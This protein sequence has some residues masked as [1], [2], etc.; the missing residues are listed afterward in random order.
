ML[1]EDAHGAPPS[2]P[3]WR[4]EA[5]DRTIELSFHVSELRKKISD[6]LS[7][8]SS[9]MTWLT[10][11][12]GLDQAGAEQ[13]LEYIQQ[14]KAV[15][16]AVPTQ[17]AVIAE[18]FFDESGGMQLIIHAPFG[19]RINKAWG[20]ALRKK[21]CRSFNFEL[22]AAATEDGLNIALAEQHSF[23]LSDVFHYLH[24]NTIK[25]VLVQAVLQSPLFTTRWRWDATRA[26][27]LIRFRNGKKVPPNIQ[28]MLSDDL[29]AAIFPD[30]AAC[31]DNLGGREIELPDHPLIN[32]TMKDCL[33]EALD[34]DGL[35]TVLN[36]ILNGSIQC[37]AVDT[38][39]PSPFSHEI[40]NA[41]P[42]AFLDD[43]PLEERRARAVEMRRILPEALLKEV[44]K[45]DPDAIQEVQEQAWP[46]IRNRDELHDF[47]QTVIALPETKTQQWQ[48]LLMELE[49]EGRIG[50]AIYQDNS[51]Y[52]PVEKLKSFIV[53]Y[54]DAII[55]NQ[56]ID[57]E[58]KSP[59]RESAM[60]NMIKGWLMHLIPTTSQELKE[61][62]QLDLTEIDQI[63]LRLESTGLILQGHYTTIHHT[64]WCE[65][66]LLA[67]IHKLT[68]ER[69]R[70]KIEPVSTA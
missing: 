52:F 70:K 61:L 37:L 41:N 46:D 36:G 55:K 5:P 54:P 24:P 43:A 40:L 25:D 45:L 18:R 68:V 65:R 22:Q 13:L 15:L 19:S 47:L 67:R 6:M 56:L 48:L 49:K 3:F 50:K 8:I 11:Y 12:C 28:R 23:P 14:G 60:L 2:V 63:L 59:D 16:G 1:V 64:E 35:I 62:L 31:Q 29:L 53:I 66:R 10:Q 69:L 42:Y 32:E 44:G 34:I 17:Q 21:F 51:F 38:P 7:D 58:K 4:G 33:T 9:A 27:A 30:A 26:L 20:L 39:I 57:I